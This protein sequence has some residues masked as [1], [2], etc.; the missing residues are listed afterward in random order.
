M[1]FQ[2]RLYWINTARFLLLGFPETK[3]KITVYILK[4]F[5]K[6][7]WG[8]LSSVHSPFLNDHRSP[9]RLPLQLHYTGCNYISY[10]YSYISYVSYNYIS[11][12]FVKVTGN[13]LV[14]DF[15]TPPLQ[16]LPSYQF[17]TW[18]WQEVFLNLT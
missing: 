3:F 13:F 4:V 5:L 11:C 9:W 1:R 7:L 14:Y 6:A 8:N 2:R 12:K 15:W 10:I 16:P 18:V 17:C